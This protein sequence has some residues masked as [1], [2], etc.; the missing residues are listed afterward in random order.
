[1]EGF[2]MKQK[3]GAPL[4]A[5]FFLHQKCVRCSD[6]INPR[7][8]EDAGITCEEIAFESNEETVKFGINALNHCAQV[9]FAFVKCIVIHIDDQQL[10]C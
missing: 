8:T 7:L 3:K 4:E 10:T 1:M 9:C 5:P 6:Q 2:N